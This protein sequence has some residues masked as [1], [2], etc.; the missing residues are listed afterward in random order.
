MSVNRDQLRR[1]LGLSPAQQAELTAEKETSSLLAK[2]LTD[3]VQ[4]HAKT[5][6]TGRRDIAVLTDKLQRAEQER[7]KYK[8]RFKI[9][10]EM[11]KRY[12]K[13]NAALREALEWYAKDEVYHVPHLG[14]CAGVAKD[15][16]R[17]AK[18]VLSR[19]PPIK[20]EK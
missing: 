18:E 11:A 10:D 1:F 2:Q 8:T 16:G 19:Y 6:A 4:E 3:E 17:R 12:F 7:D 9:R 14:A 13:E 20:E 15:R 5:I